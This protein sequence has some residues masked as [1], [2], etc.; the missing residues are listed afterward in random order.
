[1]RLEQLTGA[2]TPDDDAADAVARHENAKPSCVEVE[3][4]L[5]AKHRLELKNFGS[6]LAPLEQIQAHP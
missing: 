3:S 4:F 6:R 1:M 2:S 5:F